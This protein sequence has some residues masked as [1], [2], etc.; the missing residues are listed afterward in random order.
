[1]P[2]GRSNNRCGELSFITLILKGNGFSD[3]PHEDRG[4]YPEACRDVSQRA[5]GIRRGTDQA[6]AGGG[7]GTQAA[8]KLS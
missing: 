7:R 5:W 6:C 4:L 1:M 3:E 2:H 8:E